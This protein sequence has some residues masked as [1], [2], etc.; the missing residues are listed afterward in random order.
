MFVGHESALSVLKCRV[1]QGSVLGPLLFT[2]YT[3]LL[4]TV[5]CQSG[6][7]LVGF[8]VCLFVCFFVFLFVCFCL[9]VLF[10]FVFGCC[11]FFCFGG[12]FCR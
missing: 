9:F 3:H 10:C 12:F 5:I 7:V 8:F 2:L 4:S 1:P 11:L 6:F